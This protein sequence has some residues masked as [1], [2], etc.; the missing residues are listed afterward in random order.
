MALLGLGAGCCIH[1]RLRGK[2]IYMLQYFTT[3]L[4]L[5]VPVTH[6]TQDKP[7]TYVTLQQ[8]YFWDKNKEF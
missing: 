6:C 5:G 2:D 7:S 4:M 3:P 8:P 1:V